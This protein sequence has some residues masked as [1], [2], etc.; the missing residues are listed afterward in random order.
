MDGHSHIASYRTV[1]YCPHWEM[2]YL[3]YWINRRKANDAFRTREYARTSV[4][5]ARRNPFGYDCVPHTQTML[6]GD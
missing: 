4:G 2:A 3:R 5:F 1:R 6:C